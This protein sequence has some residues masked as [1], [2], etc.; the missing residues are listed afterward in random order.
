MILASHGDLSKSM[1]STVKMEV[2]RSRG[3]GFNIE[4]GHKVLRLVKIQTIM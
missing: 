1:L 4:G 3:F 2:G